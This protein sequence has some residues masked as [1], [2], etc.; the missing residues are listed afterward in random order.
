MRHLLHHPAKYGSVG[1]L[2][3]LIQLA[4]SQTLHH[5]LLLDRRA[6]RA[7][8]QLDFDFAFHY[9]F[10]T[11]MP[12]ISA[13][14]ARSRSD[15]RATM[16]AFTTLCGLRRPIDLVSTLGMPQAVM[17]ARTAPPAITPVPSRAG[18][19]STCELAKQP[20]TWCGIVVSGALTLR[21]AFFAASIPLRMAEG[22]SFAFPTP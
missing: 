20:S 22:T 5:Q 17:T 11:A 7:A 14:A 19:N 12:R 13:T 2:H 4:Q 3:Y 18:F 15:S 16:V 10:S 1:P 9:S 6:D 8:I 21:R